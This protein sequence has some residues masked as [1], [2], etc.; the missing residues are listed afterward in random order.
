MTYTVLSGTLNST[1]PYRWMIA[2]GES[3]Y[4]MLETVESSLVEPEDGSVR[5]TVDDHHV[6]DSSSQCGLCLHYLD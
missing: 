4:H 5:K 3:F 6:L 2:S 1:I